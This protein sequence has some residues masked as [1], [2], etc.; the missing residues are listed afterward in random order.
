MGG[1]GQHHPPGRDARRR[2][3]GAPRSAVHLGQEVVLDE[4]GDEVALAWRQYGLGIWESGEG[5]YDGQLPAEY[6]FEEEGN[7]T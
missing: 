7:G 6:G 3:Q 1:T 4:D 2:P 5:A